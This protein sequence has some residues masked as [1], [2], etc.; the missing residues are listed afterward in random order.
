MIHNSRESKTEQTRSCETLER[1]VEIS[2]RDQE[3]A[4]RLVARSFF[5]ILRGNGFTR[6]Q[7]IN[8]AEHLL[9]GLIDEMREP[10]GGEDG[11]RER[12]ELRVAGK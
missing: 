7:I 11:I 10:V 12:P 3:R 6:N 2:A 1:V 4:A 8:V 9:D 5:K